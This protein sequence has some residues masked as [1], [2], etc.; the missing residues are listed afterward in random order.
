MKVVLFFSVYFF[1]IFSGIGQTN[2]NNLQANPNPFSERT[3]LTFSLSAGD[4]ITEIVI[5]ILGQTII[6][7]RTDDILPSG[8]YQDSLVMDTYPDDI[9]FVVLKNKT[10]NI[11]NTKIIKSH[12][13]GFPIMTD[14]NEIKV[15]PNPVSEKI[16]IEFENGNWFNSQMEINSPSLKTLGSLLIKKGLRYS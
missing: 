4:T 5:N 16:Y 12:G 13:T 9:Y 14:D 1:L 10:K 11:S 7:L 6:T 3:L 8:I 2:P 15:Y